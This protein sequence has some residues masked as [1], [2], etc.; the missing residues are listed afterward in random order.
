MKLVEEQERRSRNETARQNLEKDIRMIKQELQ[1]LDSQ[2]SKNAQLEK[3]YSKQFDD[4]RNNLGI[5]IF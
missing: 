3:N 5:Y 2:I 1:K 4:K